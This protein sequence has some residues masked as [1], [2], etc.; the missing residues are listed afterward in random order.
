VQAAGLDKTELAISLDHPIGYLSETSDDELIGRATN[1]KTIMAD[2]ISILTEL[3]PDDIT[4]METAINNFKEAKDKPQEEIKDKKALGTDP[5]PGLLD[6]IDII[7]HGISNLLEAKFSD[8]YPV[9]KSRIKVG[10]PVGIRNT[11]LVIRYYDAASDGYLHK[12][13]A[14][15]ENASGSL[16]KSST[17][18]GYV[19]FFSLDTATYIVT[20][21]HP[22]FITDVMTNVGVI[23]T[24]I[25]RLDVRLTPKILSGI[26]DLT[27]F[28]KLTGN[29]LSGAKLTIPALNFQHTTSSSGKLLKNELAAASYEAYLTCDTYKRLDFTFTIE[30]KQSSILLLNME[31]EI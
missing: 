29:P 7:K 10:T 24:Q 26:L 12:V 16:V 9:W 21:E 22:N 23:N 8:L 14:T 27:V 4:A 20:S 1:L 28:D 31:K 25:V 5:I 19:R 3:E 15:V 30:S 17:K 6:D 18:K 2:N 11:S 13:K